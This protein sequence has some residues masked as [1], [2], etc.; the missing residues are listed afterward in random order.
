MEYKNR[1]TIITDINENLVN[2]LTASEKKFYD[3]LDNKKKN[4]FVHMPTETKADLMRG[5]LTASEEALIWQEGSTLA[6]RYINKGFGF[7][8]RGRILGKLGFLLVSLV[9]V[10]VAGDIYFNT[11]A[12]NAQVQSYIKQTTDEAR[13]PINTKQTELVKPENLKKA[14]Q[15]LADIEKPGFPCSPLVSLE[16][17]FYQSSGKPFCKVD[18]DKNL[19]VAG[20]IAGTNEYGNHPMPVLLFV[21]DG[22]PINIVLA[23]GLKSPFEGIPSVQLKEIRREMEKAFINNNKGESNE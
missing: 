8:E 2:Q 22:Q 12:K 9:P 23:N 17:G 7:M 1:I 13:I 19:W 4:L 16:N 18:E 21:Q 14:G 5:E 3:K 6:L 11:Y 10:L 15:F 20:Y